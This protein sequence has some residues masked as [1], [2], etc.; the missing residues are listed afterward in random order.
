MKKKNVTISL[1]KV[2]L[3]ALLIFIGAFVVLKFMSSYFSDYN[4]SYDFNQPSYQEPVNEVV[5]PKT[6]TESEIIYPTTNNLPS[7]KLV[8]RDFSWSYGLHDFYLG[9]YFNTSIYEM[10]KL[11]SR[12]RNYDLFASDPYDDF[13]MK[14]VVKGLKNAAG[15]ANLDDEELPYVVASFV[16][17]LPYTSDEVTTGFDEYP[18]FPYETLYDN[19]GDCEDTS[20]L[21]AALLQ[22]AGYG[23]VLIEILGG[24]SLPGHMAVGVKCDSSLGSYVTY[25]GEKYCYLET[26]AKGWS[27]GKLP[28]E[29]EDANVE[30][31]PIY[32]RPFLD[33]QFNSKYKYN[34]VDTYV[35]VVV[36]AT[37]LGSETAKNTKIYVALQTEDLTKVWDSVESNS[38]EIDPEEVYE[39]KVT[40][41]HSPTGQPFRIYARAYSDNVIS[42]EAV[43]EWIYWQS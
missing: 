16:Q 5:V 18:R 22:E 31:I 42:N 39:Y 11:R 2:A 43:S 15:Q 29:Y 32:K 28:S 41:L 35:D 19:G 26:T 10:Y 3:V 36:F 12:E 20:I 1:G 25:Q 17:S 24:D 33:M 13:L 30:I 9:I 34:S 27:V 8:N 23:V 4:S 7:G 14:A 37:N 38:L 40:N 21:V 6:Q